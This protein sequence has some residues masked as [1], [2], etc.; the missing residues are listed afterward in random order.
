MIS[1]FPWEVLALCPNMDGHHS[2]EEM[3]HGNCADGMMDEHD[4]EESFENK[5]LTNHILEGASWY[6]NGTGCGCL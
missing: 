1:I 2:G 4:E 6:C 5:F 3:H